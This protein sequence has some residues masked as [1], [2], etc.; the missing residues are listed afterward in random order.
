MDLDCVPSSCPKCGAEPF[1]PFLYGLVARGGFKQ[2]WLDMVA[3][4]RLGPKRGH[5]TIICWDCK[6]IVGHD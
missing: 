3:L 2:L 4:L 5:N 1:R 6:E